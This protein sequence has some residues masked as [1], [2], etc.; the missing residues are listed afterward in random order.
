MIT[1]IVLVG[2]Y[3]TWQRFKPQPTPP[4][5][6]SIERNISALGR[7]TPEGGLITL[8]VPGGPGG[9]S[10][11]VIENWFVGEGAAIR[12]GQILAQMRSYR[13]LKSQLAQAE[14]NLASSKILLPFLRIGQTRGAILFQEGAIS[15]QDLG[16]SVAA[17]ETRKAT[18]DA[19]EAGV[20]IAM[21]QLEAAQIRSPI[22]GS[23]IR[24]FSQPGMKETSDGLALIGRTN[25]MEV[26]AQ[27]YQADIDR[28]RLGQAATIRAESGGFTGTLRGTLKTIVGN[29]SSRD[30]FATNN[31][32]NVNARVV[33]AKLSLDAADIAKVKSLSG[34][35]VV[36]TFER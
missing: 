11:D 4:V 27:V 28:L 16:K 7:L 21:R 8:S 9:I 36:V 6:V 25:A 20:Q 29:V 24:I 3:T 26:W 13:Q 35:N 31:N 33:L 14:S 30:L 15:E 19:A 17:V 10:N 12:Q 34:L 2:A 1:G 32:N 5:K 23:L 18:I 22:N